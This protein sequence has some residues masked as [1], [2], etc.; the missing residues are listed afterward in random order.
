MQGPRLHPKN[1]AIFGDPDYTPK[2]QAF[3]GTPRCSLVL[4]P[5]NSY[6]K[7]IKSVSFLLDCRMM[8]FFIL[9]K[10]GFSYEKPTLII[11]YS[12]FIIHSSLK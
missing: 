11:H 4:S 8:H 7:K 1:L 3:S 9:N 12:L 2:M 5:K 10:N 6:S